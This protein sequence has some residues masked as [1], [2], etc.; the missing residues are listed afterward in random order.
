MTRQH[1]MTKE[2]PLEC[3]S[4]GVQSSNYYYRQAHPRRMPQFPELPR[5]HRHYAPHIY[6]KSS[7]R[8]KVNTKSFNVLKKNQFVE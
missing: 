4:C 2:E 5:R 6:I 1:L 7:V 8:S 3:P